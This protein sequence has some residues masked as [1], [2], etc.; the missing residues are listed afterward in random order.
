MIEAF[1]VDTNAVLPLANPNFD[2]SRY[3]PELEGKGSLR[4]GAQTPKKVTR[5]KRPAKP[6]AGWRPGGTCELEFNDGVLTVNSSGGD[7]HLSSPLPKAVAQSPLVL[8]FAIAS[9]SSGAGQIF[10]HER[11]V[12]PAFFRDRSVGFDVRHDGQSHEHAVQIRPERPV[13][14]VRIDPS[15]GAGKMKLSNIGLTDTDGTI[16]HQW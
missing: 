5:G 6:V 10:W 4:G 2:P 1:L 14:A 7:P 12:T 16:L 3:R 13:V 9:D 8:R 15:R 11:G